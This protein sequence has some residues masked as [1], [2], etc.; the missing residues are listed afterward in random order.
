VEIKKKATVIKI[1]SEELILKKVDVDNI[2]Y[3]LVPRPAKDIGS[4]AAKVDNKK[5]N[6]Y[7]EYFPSKFCESKIK[8]TVINCRS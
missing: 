8:T 3:S 4:T 1:A 6:K 2:T 5:L 7:G